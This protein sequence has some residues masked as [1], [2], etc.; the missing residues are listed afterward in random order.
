MTPRIAFFGSPMFAVP[1]LESLQEEF[2][3]VLVVSQPAKPGKRHTVEETPVTKRAI[4][5]GLAVATPDKLRAADFKTILETTPVDVAVV[6]AYG[7][8]LPQWLLDWPAK[9]MINVH[10][11]LLP[12]YR[13][14]SPISAAILAGD[15]TTGITF[16]QMNS[17]MDE[18]DMLATFEMPITPNDT[19][20]SLTEKLSHLAARQVVEVVNARLHDELEALPQPEGASYTSPLETADGEIDLNNPPADLSRRIR[21]FYPWPGVW[22]MWQGKRVKLLPE[23]LVQMEG[24]KATPLTDFLRGH[25]DFP[26]KII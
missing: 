4:E 6:A 11:S 18:G 3:V 20:A 1:V 16:M 14:A 25:A 12:R 19:T 7:K 21:A 9:G 24:K 10:G 26:I 13:G 5:L 23:G 17:K 8:I 22:G 15:E 2:E